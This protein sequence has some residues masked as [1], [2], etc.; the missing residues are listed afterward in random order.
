M[1]ARIERQR[2]KSCLGQVAL[3]L[4]VAFFRITLHCATVPDLA[5][6]A[7]QQRVSRLSRIM[8]DRGGRDI[9]LNPRLDSNRVPSGADYKGRAVSLDLSDMDN[10]LHVG[11]NFVVVEPM[12]TMEVLVASTLRY[13]LI[14]KVVPELRAMTV[15]GAIMGGAMESASHRHGMFHDVVQEYELLLANGSV[16]SASTLNNSQ[17]FQAVGGS[18]GCL[19]LLTMATVECVPAKQ[20][21]E[22]H[23]TWHSTVRAG[24]DALYNAC[25]QPVDFVD[26]VALPFQKGYLCISG[27]FADD[28]VVRSNADGSCLISVGQPWDDF[29]WEHVLDVSESLRRGQAISINVFMEVTDYLFRF[30]RGV[31]WFVHPDMWMTDWWSW[32]NP[33]KLVS[34]CVSQRNP[35]SKGL[36]RWLFTTQRGQ[37][38]IHMIPEQAI[39]SR[40]VIQDIFAPL[41]VAADC[42]HFIQTH[43]PNG[44]HLPVWTWPVAGSSSAKLFAPNGNCT[45]MMINCGI[46]GRSASGGCGEF[47]QA[48][49]HWATEHDCRKLLYSQNHYSADEFWRLYDQEQFRHLRRMFAADE[50]FPC[51]S[52]KVLSRNIMPGDL[53][54]SWQDIRDAPLAMQRFIGL[55][56]GEWFL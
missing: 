32:I 38:F 52:A 13:G 24:I 2:S 7:H 46:Y 23:Y 17:L 21:V 20:H 56:I 4:C 47:T 48:L 53:N 51:I 5:L 35:I 8:Q 28:K 25:C 44:E 11:D 3:A 42:I 50:T 16:V 14:P 43:L 12:V 31:F 40:M 18:Y 55:V 39:A 49:E 37:L 22:L 19:C 29:Y 33:I 6:K 10:V 30:D 34:F 54:A 1:A 26:G 9:A 15:G 45:G 41:D 36:F 27:S